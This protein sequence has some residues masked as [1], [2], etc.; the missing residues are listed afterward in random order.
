MAAGAGAVLCILFVFNPAEGGPY[1]TCTFHR[2]TG[3]LCPGCGGLRAAHALLH[4]RVQ[5][6]FRLNAVLVGTLP[7]LLIYGGWFMSARWRGRP[8]PGLSLR[9]VGVWAVVVI[10]YAVA[11]NL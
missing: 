5:E 8:A 2:L 4:G 3:L 7:L 10:V 11:R 6:A 1:P 9:L